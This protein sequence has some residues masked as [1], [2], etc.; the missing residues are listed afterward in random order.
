MD[1]KKIK[2]KMKRGLK[3]WRFGQTIVNR[4]V[5]VKNKSDS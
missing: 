1:C 4:F 3:D 5:L 2:I